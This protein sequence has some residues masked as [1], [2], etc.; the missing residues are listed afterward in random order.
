[1]GFFKFR[2]IQTKLVFSIIVFMALPI[3][4]LSYYTARSTEKIIYNNVEGLT[5]NTLKQLNENFQQILDSMLAIANVV[6]MDRDFT[7]LLSDEDYDTEYDIFLRRKKIVDKITSYLG[8]VLRYNCQIAFVDH[9]NNFFTT[10]S[11]SSN[12]E[13]DNDIINSNWYKEAIAL[14]GRVRW[15]ISHQSYIPEARLNDQLITMARLVKGESSFGNYGVL[16]VSL[17]VDEMEDNLN[18]HLKS[19]NEGFLIINE[20][21][22]I[23]LKTSFVEEKGIRDLEWCIDNIKDSDEGSFI[24]TFKGEKMQVVYKSLKYAGL[25]TIYITPYNYIQREVIAMQKRNMIINIAMIL[26]FIFVTLFISFRITKPIRALTR[27]M[28]KIKGEDLDVQVEVNTHD[29]VGQ[30]TETFNYMLQDLK[31]L[32]AEIAQKEKEKKE[33]HFEAL[34]AQINP[35]FLFN[36]LNAIKWASYVNGVPNIGN[37]MA[38]L[39]R[40]FEII[41]NKKSEYIQIKEEIEYLDNYIKL[42]E[43]KNNREINV[44]YDLNESILELYTLKFILQPIVENSIIHGFNDNMENAWIKITGRMEE[45]KIVLEIIDNGKGMNEEKINELLQSNTNANKHRFTGIGISNVTERIKLN[46]GNEYGIK[47]K[48]FE[49]GGT[50]V[51]VTV[52]VLSN[53]SEEELH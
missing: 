26:I 46:F 43:F 22:D 16:I 35:H 48:S 36:T 4:T 29:E 42:M 11:R 5:M 17:Y 14:G 47:I 30:L 20:E 41:I 28:A 38:S 6:E 51:I 39:G 24:G 50:T 44:D 12:F 25:K 52:P 13:E 19:E 8:I 23:V 9:N 18:N 1:M 10:W 34:Q 40:L 27:H 21:S 32:M 45:E 15:V 2:S 3:I 33:L 53:I 7:K 37:M 31:K 49:N